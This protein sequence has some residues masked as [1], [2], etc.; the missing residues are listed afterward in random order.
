MK[1]LDF[2]LA[3][4]VDGDGSGPTSQSPT[5]DAARARASIL[6]T[7]AYMSP[8]Q[9]RGQSVDKRADIWAFGCVLYE[10]LTGRV[11]FRR[12]HRL[13]HD[14]EDSRA[15]ARLV[16]A[17]RGDARAHSTASAPLSRE[18]S[19][20]APERH[21][22][23]QDRDRR[24]RR[25]PA[26]FRRADVGYRAA[27]TPGCRGSSPAR[28]RSGWRWCSCVGRRGERWRRPSAAPQ[29]DLGADGS[30]ANS[31]MNQYGDATVLSPDGTV[32]AFVAQ[33]G[34]HG[35]SAALCSP[36][37][38]TP[39]HTAIGNRRRPQLRSFRRT[40]CGSGF[41]P[42]SKLKK[43]AVTGG[44][45]ADAVAMCRSS[46]AARGART[47]RSCSRPTRRR[48]RAC[49][50]CHRTEG[51]PEPLTSLAEGEG[52]QLWPQFLP[53][54]K[55]VLYTSSAVA[56]AYNDADLV[57]QPLPGGPRK[58]VQRGGFHG[59]YLPSGHLVYIHDGTLFA[60]PF[61]LDRLEMTGPAGARARRRDVELHH[62]RRAVFR[63]GHRHAR[64]SA[65]PDDRRRHTA[66][67]DESR[68]HDVAAAGHAART[69]SIRV[70][71]PM[72]AGSRWRSGTARPTSGSTSG[73]GTRSPG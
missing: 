28:S 49:C 38:P 16:G 32:V 17:A 40:D 62:R 59:R 67:V 19:E 35:N 26:G 71:R 13:G 42:T 61:D 52:I 29:S 57:V 8:E 64:V 15:R 14:R 63:L 30:L 33:K 21:R 47:A 3:K 72:A 44:A 9:A 1:V 68:R 25:G 66:R 6:G 11:A 4:A 46:A 10:M 58:V 2:G 45:S 41:R 48:A 7:A 70:S 31:I 24:D 22:R 65:G 53:G 73:R 60:A 18:G 23:R 51:T 55:A 37:Q 54:G 56:G 69:G 36:T 20:A 50:A 43:I 27:R 39:G 12:R 5:S 34:E